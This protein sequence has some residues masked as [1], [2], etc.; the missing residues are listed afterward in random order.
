MN[1]AA[2]EK[3]KTKDRQA[4]D[5][6]AVSAAVPALLAERRNLGKLRYDYPLVLVDD[7]NTAD[8]EFIHSLS[9]IFNQIQQEIAPPGG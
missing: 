1:L 4:T 6:A 5:Q 2:L 7:L 8:Q 3:H 9:G